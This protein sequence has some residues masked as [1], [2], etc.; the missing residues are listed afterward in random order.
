M[1]TK[2]YLF[3]PA[4]DHTDEAIPRFESASAEPSGTDVTSS[5]VRLDLRDE[6]GCVVGLHHHAHDGTRLNTLVTPYATYDLVETNA[7]GTT[8]SDFRSLVV[9]VPSLEEARQ[10]VHSTSPSSSAA[11]SGARTRSG[12]PPAG[13]GAMASGHKKGRR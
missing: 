3:T 2:S 1:D 7:S 10:A 12:K 13:A 4:N 5:S 11:A 8:N 9:H 6:H